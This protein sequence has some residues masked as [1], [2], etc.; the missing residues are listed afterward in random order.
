MEEPRIT[1]CCNQREK[2]GEY[3]RDMDRYAK[4]HLSEKGIDETVITSVEAIR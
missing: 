1:A 3:F 2:L 4:Q